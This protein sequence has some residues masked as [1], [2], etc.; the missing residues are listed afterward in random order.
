MEHTEFVMSSIGVETHGFKN[1]K[2]AHWNHRPARLYQ[3]AIERGEGD[4][5]SHGVFLVQTGEHTGRSAQDK[6]IVRDE[7]TQETVWWDNNKSMTTE[8]FDNLLEDM[9]HY[10]ENK[11]IFIQDLFCG[12]DQEY[13]LPS[14]I[15]TEYAWH[16]LFIQNLLIEPSKKELEHFDPEFILIHLPR[17][18]AN[19]RRHGSRDKTMIALNFQRKI[20]LISGTSY[21]GEIKKSVFS[22]LN[23]TLPEKHVLPMHC[24]VNIEKNKSDSAIFFG[25]SGTGKTT[26]SADPNR[27]LIGDD[28]HGWS[29]KGVFNFE[30]GCYA[31]MIHLS[32][33]SEPAIY[34][35]TQRFGTIIENVPMDSHSRIL[36]FD[37]N[38]LTENTRA[39][40]PLSF[41]PN[42]STTG[43][44]GHPKTI[45]MLTADAFS[46][47]PPLARLTPSQAIYHF[48]SG[49]TSKIAGTEKG[50]IEPE[51][52][53]ST[54]FG[55]PFMP[56]HPSIYGDL[57]C[58]FITKHHVNCWIINTGWTGGV[59]GIGSRMPIKQ[60]RILLS[61]ALNDQLNDVPFRRDPYFGFDV[62]I[63]V[64]HADCSLLNP[65]ETWHDKD[66]YDVQ[67]RQLVDMFMR[68]FEQFNAYVDDDVKAAAPKI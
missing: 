68:N 26:L 1:L 5:T 22:M 21:A 39:A 50:V 7:T 61:A 20:A 48:L 6:F 66:A 53:F 34:A 55:A 18:C 11:E 52:T 13:R 57:L 64:P 37:D 42:A 47:F 23:F 58:E 59:Y 33:E 62:P 14:R 67:A 46:I 4:I 8:Q 41:I 3:M 43:I 40:Y 45:I 63:T 17:F 35:T 38:S 32:A 60:T 16:S 51:A 10:A 15:Y 29:T 31:K 54:C 2:S 27:I 12:S 25:L 28:E 19:K 9:H 44:A 49:Y 36:D 30:G 65:S 24:S 56:R